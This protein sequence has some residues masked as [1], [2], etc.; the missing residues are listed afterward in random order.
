MATGY[1]QV[2]TT[3]RLYVSYPL[4]Q[5]ASGAL[6]DVDTNFNQADEDLIRMI[7]LDPSNTTYLDINEGFNVLKYRVVPS[8]DTETDLLESN[9]FKPNYAMILGHN[10]QSA[11]ARVQI[12]TSNDFGV[13]NDLN[14][15]SLVN[16]IPNGPPEYDGWS[17]MGLDGVAGQFDYNFRIGFNSEGDSY[18]ETPLQIGSI[19]FGRY[20]TF[21]QN[22]NLS[23][24]TSFNYGV[25]QKQT[26]A[27]KTISTSNWS[28]PNN[29]I[30]EPFGLGDERGDNYQRRSGVRSWKIDFDSLAPEKVMNQNMMMNSNGYTAQDNHSTG[31][32]GIKSLYNINDA[33]D[34][35][36]LVVNKCIANHLPMV[37]QIDKDDF[38]PSSFA[39]CR[40]SGKNYQIKQK[41]PNL[42][43][44]SLNLIEQV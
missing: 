39:I 42:Y 23:T 38:S 43:N 10:L 24:T 41:S 40:I 11:G 33:E 36:T 27:G 37:L 13:V 6:D 2:A 34:F 4:W 28:K 35:F 30:T 21:P 31:A 14:T 3:P 22:C 29:W 9:L 44:I 25:K 8:F 7:T 1:Y 19:L 32:D 26:L 16:Y 18:N 12:Q 20:F 5:Y 15:S 17:L